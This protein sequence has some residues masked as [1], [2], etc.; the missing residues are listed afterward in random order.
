[1]DK[2]YSDYTLEEV[3]SEYIFFTS[4]DV[5]RKNCSTCRLGGMRNTLIIRLKKLSSNQ[6]DEF[7]KVSE[8]YNNEFLKSIFNSV[9]NDEADS[10]NST[11]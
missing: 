10:D 1:M 3:V 7:V 8:K 5:K 9:I 11:Y 4:D 2:Y 6:F